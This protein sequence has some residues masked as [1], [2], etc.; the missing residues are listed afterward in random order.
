MKT[1]GN[2]IVP[3][4][5]FGIG[6][7]ALAALFVTTL[8]TPG[9]DDAVTVNVQFTRESNGGP[10]HVATETINGV[11]KQLTIEI[12]NIDYHHI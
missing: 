9:Q 5:S 12:V 2:R 4:A 8:P 3:V 7:L 10:F 11:S 6:L 1:S